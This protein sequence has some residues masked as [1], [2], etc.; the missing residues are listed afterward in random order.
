[1]QLSNRIECISHTRGLA[2]L[3]DKKA[4]WLNNLAVWSRETSYLNDDATLFTYLMNQSLGL[5]YHIIIVK[6]K[7]HIAKLCGLKHHR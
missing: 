5:L 2:P 7:H 1:M 4:V 6:S 3:I